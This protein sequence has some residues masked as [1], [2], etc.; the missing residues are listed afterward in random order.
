MREHFFISENC[1]KCGIQSCFNSL[2]ALFSP[3]CYCYQTSLY[4]RIIYVSTVY[5]YIF[6]RPSCYN[7]ETGSH[8]GRF[9]MMRRLGS[10][11]FPRIVSILSVDNTLVRDDDS[12]YHWIGKV[13]KNLE[14]FRCKQAPNDV[15]TCHLNNF[16]SSCCNVKR[17]L[18]IYYTFLKSLN[19]HII[20]QKSVDQC[21][22][23]NAVCHWT[24]RNCAQVGKF[25]IS[26]RTSETVGGSWIFLTLS[27]SPTQISSSIYDSKFYTHFV[28]RYSVGWVR[29]CS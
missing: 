8:T 25:Y 9:E 13:H 4:A 7:K 12:V 20:D 11:L 22:R 29:L 23:C 21:S 2:P 17:R 3:L 26:T 14:D 5:V 15:D 28:L 18:V 24:W 16:V 10:L 6:L 1:L 27:T 19:K